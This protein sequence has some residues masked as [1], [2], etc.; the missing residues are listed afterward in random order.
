MVQIKGHPDTG[1]D[2]DDHPYIISFHVHCQ[3]VRRERVQAPVKNYIAGRK[4]EGKRPLWRDLRVDGILLLLL[5]IIITT[6]S[7]V[8]LEKPITPHLLKKFPIFYGIGG[9]VI[10]FITARHLSVFSGRQSSIWTPCIHFNIILPSA[11]PSSKYSAS[12]F[13]TK[14]LY[15]PLLLVMKTKKQQ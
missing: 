5:I 4:L 11:P 3:Q 7:G 15:T 14:T 8:L 1:T 2:R 6:R 13:P 12:G 10:V 9:C